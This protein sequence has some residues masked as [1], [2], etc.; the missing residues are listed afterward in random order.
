MTTALTDAVL[1][2]ALDYA[3]R[4]WRVVPLYGV[5]NTGICEC[6]NTDE[7]HKGSRGKHPRID[8]WQNAATTNEDVIQN[9]WSRWPTANVGVH[10]GE[11]SGLV[12]FDTDS[13]EAEQT[14]L[15]LHNGNPPVVPTYQSARGK[16]YLYRWRPDLPNPD[17]AR[18]KLGTLDILTG[19]GERGQQSVF[20][21]SVRGDVQYR[22]LIHPDECDLGEI[23]D[24][25]FAKLHNLFGEDVPKNTNGK[26]R[27]ERMK[28]YDHDVVDEGGR[29][30]TLY[31]EACNL[32]RLYAAVRGQKAFHDADTHAKVSNQIW[33][34]NKAKCVPPLDDHELATLIESARAGIE[35]AYLAEV[36]DGNPNRA[37]HGL[38]WRD[39]EFWPGSWEV[40]VLLGSPPYYYL[41]VPAWDA[42]LGEEKQIRFT[43]EE[44]RD[45]NAVAHKIFEATKTI[46]V[47]DKPGAWPALWNGSKGS[48]KDKIEPTRGLKA[49][50]LDKSKLE[51]TSAEWKK[52]TLLAETMSEKLLKTRDADVPNEKG[53]PI[54]MPDGTV[55]VRW[56]KLWEEEINLKRVTPGELQILSRT[57][58]IGPKNSKIHAFTPQK[59]LRYTVLTPEHLGKLERMIA[60]PE[61]PAGA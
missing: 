43:C 9:W 5:R 26:P 59:R 22:W 34:W 37:M 18:F 7:G 47:D 24:E 39:G 53:L 23:T 29:N 54:R 56:M 60:I 57:I 15:R 61:T 32:W 35:K 13:E 3:A 14:Y 2:A 36:S 19:N 45:A 51:E 20:P 50:L 38:E 44:Y 12:D 46:I 33:A 48:K 25:M 4:G 27:S 55:W 40:T 16:H 17:K 28:L 1:K 52:Q 11:A 6:G 8:D 41:R 42:L 58:G 10:M 21:P 49:K 30:D 31:K